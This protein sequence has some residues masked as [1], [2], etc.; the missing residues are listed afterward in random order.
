MLWLGA[1][2]GRV[3]T[4]FRTLFGQHAIYPMWVKVV[5]SLRSKEVLPTRVIFIVGKV[6]S[7]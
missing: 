1:A 7:K 6:V 3:E 4:Y 2:C 5:D